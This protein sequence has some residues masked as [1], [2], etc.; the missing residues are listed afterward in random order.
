MLI[1]NKIDLGLPLDSS[2]N[3]E[4]E[5]ILKHNNYIFSSGID[6]IHEFFNLE[7]KTKSTILTKSVKLLGENTLVN[8]MFTKIAD[9]GITF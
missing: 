2:I 7:R 3:S 5:K 6:L 8:K 1:K 9:R 4:F